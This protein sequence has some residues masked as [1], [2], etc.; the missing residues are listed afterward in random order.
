[1]VEH[2]LKKAT[3]D[4]KCPETRRGIK[5]GISDEDFG[6]EQD[7]ADFWDGVGSTAASS[8]QAHPSAS[9]VQLPTMTDSL[10]ACID[11]SDE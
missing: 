11:T 1:M 2:F 9:L 7:V 10:A 6:F 4:T 5:R 8:S 3:Q